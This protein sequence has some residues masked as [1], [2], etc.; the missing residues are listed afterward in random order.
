MPPA[1]SPGSHEAR[2][3]TRRRTPDRAARIR[4]RRA[5]TLMLMT[6][7]VPGSAQLVAGRREVGRLAIRIWMGLVVAVALVALLAWSSTSFALWAGT[8][9][10][11]L[12]L[13]R[14]VIMLV[15]IGWAALFIDAWRLGEPLTLVR[16]QRLAM[17][18]INGVLCFS[19][20]GTLLF[21]AHLITVQRD[22]IDTVF[23]A[24][25]VS[26]ATHGRYNV[27]LIGGDSADGRFGLRPDSLNV[28]SIDQ[29]TGETV[30]I[31][32]PRNLQNFTFGEG[33]VMAEQFPDGW[34]CDDCY[35][36]SVATWAGDNTELFDDAEHAGTQATI[37][38]VEGITG[39]KINYWVMVNLKGFEQLVDAVGGVT[40]NVMDPIPIGGFS[41]PVKGYIEPGLQEL[42]GYHA[43][44]FARSRHGSDDYSRMARQK[45]VMNAIA[46]QVSP[47]TVLMNFKEITEAGSSMM[48]TSIPA[49][50]LDNFIDLALK[51]RKH[52]IGTVSIVP[53]QINTAHPDLELIREMVAQGINPDSAPEK[54]PEPAGGADRPE[55]AS[56]A[57]P[58]TNGGSVGSKKD[59]YAANQSEDLAS[60]C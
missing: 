45:C 23:T 59:G 19:V 3:V 40:I 15:A 43:L 47:Q 28:A 2:Y 37:E 6:L 10:S 4:F 9:T 33:S 8:N 20:A 52:E 5:I 12:N 50:E 1:T 24:T 42:D 30:L 18:G 14:F 57:S 56:P 60:V 22:F 29:E 54:A 53:P 21:A 16:N 46:T 58:V 7:V 41:T 26:E 51:A 34:T 48:E 36:N 11:V 27:L 32:L 17:V 49:S 55:Q 39:L 44:W 13:V 25:E 38:A 31:G 35:L